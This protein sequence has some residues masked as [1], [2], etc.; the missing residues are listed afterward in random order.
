M[1]I[2]KIHIENFRSIKRLTF[3]PGDLCALVGANGTGK[4]NILVALDFL[5][6]DRFPSSRSLDPSDYFSHD[7]N[8]TVKIGVEFEPNSKNIQFYWCKFEPNEKD[9]VRFRYFGDSDSKYVSNDLREHMALVYVDAHRDLEKH[10]GQSKWSVWGRILRQFN[11]ALPDENKNKLNFHF[12]ETLSWL[13]TTEF[14]TFEEELQSAFEDQ[15][16]QVNKL[17]QV[18]FKTFDPLSYYKSIN[19]LLREDEHSVSLT[20]AGQGMRNMTIIA[21][22]RAYAKIFKGDGIVAI[23]EPE[24]YLHPH[25]E[26]SLAKLFRELVSQGSQLF[27][28]THSSRFVDI[29]HFDEICM[30]ERKKDDEGDLCTHL[31]KV[32]VQE[33]IETRKRLYP[34]V[35]FSIDSIRNRYRNLC[36]LEHAEAFF[37]R[38]VV[39]VEGETEEHALPI[40]ASALDYDLDAH[41]VSVVNAYG[42]NNL[43]Q[44]YQLYEAFGIPVYLIFDSDRGSQDKSSLDCNEKLLKMLSEPAEREPI[45]RV[46]S[47]YAISQS[48]FEDEIKSAVGANLYDELISQAKKDLGNVGKGIQARFVASWLAE[49]DNIPSYVQRI[50]DKVRQL[51]TDEELD[52][53]EKIPF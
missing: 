19:F 24:L 33:F 1:K 48:N 29:E 7:E 22:F 31:R 49:Q 39:L 15:V 34:E 20:Q 6:G 28:T 11:A 9:E 14:K 27:Y 37:A 23:E 41:G 2:R 8:R 53:S 45:G 12:Q 26:R 42:K 47:R 30:I 16:R 36:S 3:E 44:L 21:L 32:S 46:E 50:V 38:K 52:L 35:A 18:E 40:Y 43:D 13:R 10:L 4:S 17:L 5:L 51:G 25:A